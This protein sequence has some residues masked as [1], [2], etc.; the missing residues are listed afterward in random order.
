MTAAPC[1]CRQTD[2]PRRM[3]NTR[4]LNQDTLFFSKRV[5]F[6]RTAPAPPRIVDSQHTIAIYSPQA[7]AWHGMG[8]RSRRD[9]AALPLVPTH[10]SLLM[11]PGERHWLHWCFAYSGDWLIVGKTVKKNFFTNTPKVRSLFRGIFPMLNHGNYLRYVCST[12]R[13]RRMPITGDAL[14]LRVQQELI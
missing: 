2:M 3:P 4:V 12:Y 5:Q 11:R 7:E 8:C 10:E 9:H 1:A 6:L 14:V 13:W